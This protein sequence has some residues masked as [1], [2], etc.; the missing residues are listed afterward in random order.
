M[1]IISVVTL[2]S[3]SGEYGG[4]V[5][6]ALNQASALIS[7]GHDVVVAG[8]ARGWDGAPPT[9]VDGVPVRLFPAVRVIPGT[10]FAGLA[11]PGLGRWLASAV[12]AADVVHVHLARDLVTLPAADAARR[13]GVPYVVQ[14]HGMVDRTTNPLAGPLDR[15]LTR[16][17]LRAARRVLYL[18][19]RER[20][21][22]AEVA[23][24]AL[25]LRELRNGVPDAPDGERTA[26]PSAS[27]DVL[28]L[29]RLAQRKRPAL[30]VE[31]ARRLSVEFPATTFSLAGPDEGEATAVDAAIH[32]APAA[33][34]VRRE[35][36]LPPE[37]TSARL[38]AA[39]V[40]VLPSV[41]EPYPMSVLEAMSVGLPV[42]VT[43]TCGLAPAIARHGCGF[44]VDDSLDA[45][46]GAVRRLLGDDGLADR[47]GAAGRRAA[48]EEFG[49][50][51]V[52]DGLV[53]AYSS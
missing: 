34:R 22:L 28:Y 29:A 33:D 26:P 9:E 14:T 45:L 4:P 15:F 49:M 42:V 31:M 25:A 51:A 8:A 32:R 47:M 11:S 39:R 30:F 18:T 5:R 6:V 35:G 10:G 44:V 53:A 52:T 24:P 19:P 20:D 1:R 21:D 37:A 23:G 41:D 43:D 38:R 17:V 12:R 2:V 40:Y 46:T 50:A 13:R 7:A 36:A 16:P 48:R 27:D 3:P